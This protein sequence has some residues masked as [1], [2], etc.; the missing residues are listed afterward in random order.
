MAAFE[1]MYRRFE[2]KVYHY[3]LSSIQDDAVARELLAEVMVAVWKGARTF[4]GESQVS[5]W[6]FGIARHKVLDALRKRTR[7]QSSM[8]AL[9]QAMALADPNDNPEHRAEQQDEADTVK[10]AMETL[11]QEHREVLYFAFYEELPYQDI[12][13]LI[14]A[15]VN[16]VKTR[17]FYAKQQLKRALEKRSKQENVP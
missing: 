11:S 8:V 14:G 3:I 17:V 9:D 2:A 5:T 4:K 10:A 6:I 7:H 12:A 15:P 16:T 1:T 13:T